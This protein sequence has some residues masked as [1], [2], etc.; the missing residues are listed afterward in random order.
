MIVPL[1]TR[2]LK[3]SSGNIA[4]PS[5]LHAAKLCDFLTVLPCTFASCQ[6][7]RSYC[8][9]F[10]KVVMDGRLGDCIGIKGGYIGVKTGKQNTILALHT[11]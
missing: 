9:G 7:Q 6:T 4:M 1:S 2:G 5:G 3:C 11:K 10:A 8:Q